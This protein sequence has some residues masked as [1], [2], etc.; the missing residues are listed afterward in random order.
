MNHR[1]TRTMK[2]ASL[3]IAVAT[4]IGVSPP[5]PS[6]I[7]GPTHS[8]LTTEDFGVSLPSHVASISPEQSGTLVELPVAEGEVVK[9]GQVLFRLSSQLQKLRVDRLETLTKSDLAVRRAKA[10]FEHATR[11][12]AR[13]G[14]LSK[15][16][17]ASG[18]EIQNHDLETLLARLKYEQAKLDQVLLTNELEQARS[19]LEQLT[20]RSPIDGVVTE[21]FKHRG[22]ASEKL[23]PVLQVARL[24]P[25]WVEFECP[26]KNQE[27]YSIGSTVMLSP[28]ARPGE[29]RVGRVV[30][31]SDQA[32]PSSHTFRVRVAL[33][34]KG[35]A[36]KAGL[37]M[38][39]SP[40]GPATGSAKPGHPKPPK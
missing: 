3:C 7:A 33:P 9:Q 23:L 39:I 22:E 27:L 15:R 29:T 18:A 25:L 20:V 19:L 21:L 14:E 26:V 40:S 5:W 6:E 2:T 4:L 17:I 12:G 36:W 30:H 24:D 35:H 28:S 13:L 31:L 37:K 16:N 10:A 34:N 1:D 38:R 11:L 32:N 8:P